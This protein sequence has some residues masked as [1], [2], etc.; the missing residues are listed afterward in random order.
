MPDYG[1]SA[2]FH[3]PLGQFEVR[4]TNAPQ[5]LGHCRLMAAAMLKHIGAPDLPVLVA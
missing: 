2:T 4:L 5:N 1:Q 3:A